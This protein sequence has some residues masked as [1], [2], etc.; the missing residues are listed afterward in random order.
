M[1]ISL[2]PLPYAK[3][4]LAP[5]ISANTL[6]FHYGKHH[7]AYVDNV[8]K[9]IEGTDLAEKSLEEI[10]KISAKDT[11]KT[12]I[13]NNAAQVWNHSFYWQC[14][15]KNGGAPRGPV[16]DKI[17]TVWGGF[18]K[19]ADE[20]K[21]AGITQFG[22]GWAWLVLEGNQLKITKTANADT[23]IAHGQKPLLTIDVWEHA[24]YLDYQNRRTDYLA[25]VI[26]NLIN[27]DFVNANLG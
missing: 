25:A 5:Y 2:P 20:L 21:N 17:K 12:G 7:K 1:A 22:S 4:A 26:Q 19:F 13:F 14:L 23:P 3:D 10:I 27:W 24:Y 16:A 18:E 9:L 6:D 15:K 11:A 8:N